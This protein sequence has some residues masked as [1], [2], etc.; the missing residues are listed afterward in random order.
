LEAGDF[1]ARDE[2]VR[3]ALGYVG[4]LRDHIDKEDH[5]LFPM[6]DEMIPAAQQVTLTE[7]FDTIEHE[8]TGEGVHEKYLAIADALEQEAAR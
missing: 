7:R 2:V 4:L 6:A 1:T 5:V 3:N 8:E